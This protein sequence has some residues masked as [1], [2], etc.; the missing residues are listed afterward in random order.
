MKNKTFFKLFIILI[1]AF[2]FR[3]WMLDKP[4]GL[5]NDEYVSWYIASRQSFTEFLELVSKNCHTPL[6]YCFLK[7]WLMIFPDTD[8]SLRISSVTASLLMIPALFSAGKEYKDNKTGLLCAFF[9]ALSSFYIYFAQEA[10][11]YSLLGL[12]CALL[13]L[14]CIKTLKYGRKRDF[15]VFALLNAV[16][17]ALHTL[18]L[19]FSFFIILFTLVY[20]Y[21]HFD[22]WKQAAK[23]CRK[24]LVYIFPFI[25]VLLLI[26][27]FLFSIL[28]SNSLSQFWSSFSYTKTA[29]SFIDYFSPMQL[30]IN[31]SPDTFRMYLF[32]NGSLNWNFVI[33]ALFP[34]FIAFAAL[35][36]GFLLKDK[37]LNVLIYSS[38]CFFTVLLVLSAIGKMVL[39]TKYSSEIY[40]VLI[41]VFS[42]G[43]LSI[44][45][46]FIKKAALVLYFAV[47]LVYLYFSP[48]SAPKLTRPEGNRAPVTL[49]EY[50]SL[51]KGDYII[52]TYYDIDKFE[53]Y[54][55]N[56]KDYNIFSIS[57][58][59]FNKPVF[60]SS[61]YF[62]VIHNGKSLYRDEF[63][64][65]PNP[66]VINYAEKMF[67]NRMKKGDRIGII[68]LEG[69]SF[70][71]NETIQEIVNDDTRYR[72]TSF[73]FLAFSMLRNSLMYAFKDDFKTRS[74]TQA[75]SWTLIV[76]EKIR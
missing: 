33:F 32:K 24:T 31:N 59:N 2:L 22:E 50:S 6:Y 42:A 70:F 25:C 64:K 29:F 48:V 14:M 30:N 36:K 20:L 1:I 4:E 54:M 65:F 52:F 66:N 8:I 37:I 53:R 75:G 13:V 10:R 34:S 62:E 69:V 9:A 26:S 47:S 17:C 12:V 72:K 11:L 15:A 16:L 5:W 43:I 7:L 73:I 19:V 18:G 57:K 60:N 61:N 40:P 44:K 55:K 39:L 76:Y 23:N 35:V 68:Y 27:P 46:E 56:T 38:G 45:N 71:S 74:I 28:F 51:R 58:F 21:K 49:I 41:L 67:I 3:V 63:K